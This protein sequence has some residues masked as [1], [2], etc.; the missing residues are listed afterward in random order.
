MQSILQKVVFDNTIQTYLS[1]GITI[2]IALMVKRF[3]SK[4]L[5]YLL[6]RI[7]S[8]AGR[9]FHKQSFMELI[10]SPL[11]WFLALF[12]IVIA[13]D[14]LTLP[15][16]FDFKIYRVTTHTI[17][18]A[19][20]N[21][22]LII[23]FIRLCIRLVMFFALILEEK[24]SA[25]QEASNNQLIVFFKDFLKVILILIGGML[26]LHFSFSYNVSNLLTGL[27]LVGAAIALATKESLE[28][29]IAS[30][31]IF[32]DK[33]FTMGDTV[34]VNGFTGAVERIGLRST[35]I[36]TDQKTYIT[37]PNKQM[38]DTILDNISLRSQRKVELRL[39]IGLSATVNDLR[40][41]VT[42]IQ[43]RLDQES[44]VLSKAVFIS[45]TGKNAH[46]ITVDYFT[47]MTQSNDEFNALRQEINLSIISLL[48]EMNVGLAA[49]NTDVVIHQ[50]NAQ[51]S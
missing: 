7:F 34:K 37:V 41:V 47:A 48:V 1:V 26:V 2:L 8:K 23:V 16:L 15:A 21:A 39:E 10:I 9:T 6:F 32:F 51:A 36:R 25:S 19:V 18:D 14:K 40:M 17:L 30:F 13:L 35:R 22:I 50:A 44:A 29:L 12:M 38:V 49:A 33:P 3:V 43:K 24:A 28:N 42:A 20:A 5:A 27:S 11:E 46:V 45:D 4:Y 31:I